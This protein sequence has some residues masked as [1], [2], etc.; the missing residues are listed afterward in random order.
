MNVSLLTKPLLLFQISTAPEDSEFVQSTSNSNCNVN[1]GQSTKR[2]SE[3]LS[4]PFTPEVQEISINCPKTDKSVK[5]KLKR[6]KRLKPK[7]LLQSNEK[8]SKN[9]NNVTLSDNEP[10]NINVNIQDV[11]VERTLTKKHFIKKKNDKS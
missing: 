8:S 1:L 5:R 9:K 3:T 7:Q 11:T 10:I 2:K 6:A 4:R